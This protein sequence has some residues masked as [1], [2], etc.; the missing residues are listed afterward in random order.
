MDSVSDDEGSQVSDTSTENSDHQTDSEISVSSSGNE[1]D[2]STDNDLQFRHKN[3]L[4]GRNNYKWSK[5]P[6]ATS[7]TPANKLVT[8]LTGL[9]V[10]CRTRR[11]ALAIWFAIMDIAAVNAH[12]VLG[13]TKDSD[14]ITRR[15]FLV[16]LGRYLINEH[17]TSR[18]AIKNL[19]RELCATISRIA[20]TARD[21]QLPITENPSKRRSCHICPRTEDQKHSTYC[22]QCCR[23]VCKSHS[24][25][26][27]TCD[28]CAAN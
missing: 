18:S 17:L 25:Q 6:P 3:V 4:L 28:D 20:G 16:S 11:W 23:G 12:V 14:N 7:R 27:I 2:S 9:A 21:E 22:N 8:K 1:D 10:G 5:I 26:S 19:S 13:A 24:V 15:D